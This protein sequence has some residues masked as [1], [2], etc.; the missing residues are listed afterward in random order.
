MQVCVSLRY[1]FGVAVCQQKLQL[2]AM[3]L[4]Y[5]VT[6]TW[7]LFLL[8][9][10][11][12]MACNDAGCVVPQLFCWLVVQR[13][14]YCFSTGWCN[15]TATA[16]LLVCA[17]TLLLLFYWLL[18]R[19]CWCCY[20]CCWSWSDY[21]VTTPAAE[22]SHSSGQLYLYNEKIIYATTPP[23]YQPFKSEDGYT[24][25]ACKIKSTRNLLY[26]WVIATCYRLGNFSQYTQLYLR[27][28]TKD[29]MFQTKNLNLY[30]RFKCFYFF[31]NL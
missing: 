22:L 27:D 26:W 8:L 15:H 30:R 13:Y 21:V 17:V 3:V 2:A 14:S 23:D 4:D 28:M 7:L 29:V 11:H 31:W 19:Y 18:L 10:M 12:S 24:I 16:F 6:F 5:A 20:S 25:H 9:I 1:A